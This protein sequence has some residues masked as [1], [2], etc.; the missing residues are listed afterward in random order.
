M[1]CA[2]RGWLG[3]NPA[4]DTLHKKRRCIFACQA[5]GEVPLDLVFV[6]G[7]ISNL[8]HQWDDSR[9]RASAVVAIG[10]FTFDLFNKRGTGL[11]DRVPAD[12][13]PTLKQRMDDM[14]YG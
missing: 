1:Y 10:F 14:G 9:A 6:H 3:R 8:E 5:V 13:L 11:S 2:T 4:Q 7:F 12:A